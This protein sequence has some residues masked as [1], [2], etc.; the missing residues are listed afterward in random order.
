MPSK[1]TA[2]IVKRMINSM[3]SAIFSIILSK[4]LGAGAPSVSVMGERRD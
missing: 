3:L 4:M 2:N 1:S